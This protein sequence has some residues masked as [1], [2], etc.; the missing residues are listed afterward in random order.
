MDTKE[1]AQ[2]GVDLSD[3]DALDNWLYD[4]VWEADN[5]VEVGRAMVGDSQETP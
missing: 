5:E 1:L 3:P 2:S 4:N